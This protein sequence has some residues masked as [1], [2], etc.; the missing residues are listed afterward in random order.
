MKVQARGLE[1]KI[2]TLRRK[3]DERGG[4]LGVGIFVRYRGEAAAS[5]SCQEVV[6]QIVNFL[7]N[8][9]HGEGE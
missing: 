3:E 6:F 5:F 9:Q 7:E 2:E 1:E 4:C 8:D